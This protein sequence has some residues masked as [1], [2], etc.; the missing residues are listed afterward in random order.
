MQVHEDE[1]LSEEEESDAEDTVA[2][3]KQLAWSEH[4]MREL[5]SLVES[6]VSFLYAS[7]LA[8]CM[9]ACLQIYGSGCTK[10]MHLPRSN[11]LK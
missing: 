5:E 4:R 1:Q 3:E 9:P 11:H 6:T 2:L 7:N 8:L 10:V